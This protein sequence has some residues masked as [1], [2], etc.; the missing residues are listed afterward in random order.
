MEM[1]LNLVLSD[2]GSELAT[3]LVPD[4]MSAIDSY[5]SQVESKR[6]RIANLQSSLRHV[7]DEKRQK[8]YHLHAV[9][10]HEGEA[11]YGHYW[12]YLWDKLRN[13]WIKF[14]DSVVTLVPESVVYQN[15]SGKNANVY[16]LAYLH[17]A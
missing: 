11:S 4:L 5:K 10:M 2:Q 8:K 3:S 1:S 14:N 9:F 16:A 12:I 13:R 17:D 15:T 6:G 7:F